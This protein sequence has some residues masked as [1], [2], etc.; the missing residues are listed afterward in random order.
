MMYCRLLTVSKLKVP[1]SLLT[2]SDKTLYGRS[3]LPLWGVTVPWTT[4][5]GAVEFATSKMYQV[6]L[7]FVPPQFT[8]RNVTFVPKPTFCSA[9]IPD[10][11]IGPIDEPDD[12]VLV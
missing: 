1:M 5:S 6:P 8:I 7:G 3:A 2:I 4:K 9:A 12:V 11:S 10:R